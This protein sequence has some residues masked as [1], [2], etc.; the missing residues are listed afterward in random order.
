MSD[1]FLSDAELETLA[2]AADA[3]TLAAVGQE[4][5]DRLYRINEFWAMQAFLRCLFAPYREGFVEMRAIKAQT[6]PGRRFFPI[7]DI[8]ADKTA[9]KETFRWATGYQNTGHAIY[10][11]V[12]PRAR[13]AGTKA[14]IV[15]GHWIWAD[16]DFKL[17]DSTVAIRR[18]MNATITPDMVVLSGNGLHAYWLVPQ[19]FNL[20]DTEEVRTF[21]K[22]LKR[23]QQIAQP[24]SDPV[25]D[26]SRVLRLPGFKNLKNKENPRPVTLARVPQEFQTLSDQRILFHAN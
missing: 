18:V 7:G 21:E 24:G 22:S 11:G 2:L 14:D 16:V 15:T 10:C 19:G 4:Y 9:M 17:E 5:L 8:W 20:S 12:L 26:I 13:Q 23:F 3:E 25:Q 1:C 6:R